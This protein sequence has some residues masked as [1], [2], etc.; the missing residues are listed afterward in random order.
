VSFEFEI[1]GVEVISAYQKY[2]FLL[3]YCLV[4]IIGL[5]FCAHKWHVHLIWSTSL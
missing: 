5:L 3:A 1:I 2:Q 4:I